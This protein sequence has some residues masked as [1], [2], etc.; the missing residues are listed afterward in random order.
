MRHSFGGKVNA[1]TKPGIIKFYYYNRISQ[2]GIWKNHKMVYVIIRS[3]ECSK[4][5]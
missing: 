5:R 4:K 1:G 3:F 2:R